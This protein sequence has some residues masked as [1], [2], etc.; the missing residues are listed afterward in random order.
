MKTYIYTISDPETGYIR[1]VGK[2]N[3]IKDRFRKH[4]EYRDNGKR[5]TY[6][7]SWMR[8]L[9]EDPIIEIIEECDI[10]DWEFY[11]RYWIS[12]LLTWGF[13]LTNLTDGGD[14]LSKFSPEV[15]KKLRQI[16]KGENNPMYGRKHS[17]ESIEKIQKSREWYKGPSEETIR[18][19]SESK[20]GHEVSEETRNKLR[21][22]N[23]EGRI[24]R[25]GH[26]NSEE[27]NKSISDASSIPIRCLETGEFFKSSTEA[28]IIT[29]LS[30]TQI[31]YRLK[32]RNKKPV[33]LNFEYV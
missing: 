2:S 8:S 27:H 24:G 14:S 19:I 21:I 32:K 6:L 1:Y 31:L 25:R 28:S 29:G 17:K 5:K 33:K 9:K 18:K 26:S 22:A 13:K 7:Y 11:E 10:S 16:N 12:Q 15:I 30:K 4:L 20:M 3:N 23:L